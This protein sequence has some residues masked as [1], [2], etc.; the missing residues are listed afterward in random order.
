MTSD[1]RIRM[2]RADQPDNSTPET[3][4]QGHTIVGGRPAGGTSRGGRI[5]RGMEILLKK[6]AVDA[7][8]CARLLLKRS[9][10]SSDLGL[11]LDQAERSMLDAIPEPQ[12][13]AIVAGT[14]VP[15]A[16]KRVLATGSAAAIVALLAQMTFSPVAA[17]AETP[18]D[19]PSVSQPISQPA[20]DSNQQVPGW[21]SLGEGGAR[22]DEPRHIMP[23]GGAR[24]DMPRPPAPPPE[25]SPFIEPEPIAPNEQTIKTGSADF[26][27]RS[28]VKSELAGTTFSQG[29]AR[30]QS[31]IQATITWK[32][33]AQPDWNR[34][35][36]AVTAG[37]GL[38]QALRD[39][40]R[41]LYPEQE[42]EVL[43]QDGALTVLVGD[44]SGSAYSSPGADAIRVPS[45]IPSPFVKPPP[46]P[47]APVPND[48][49]LQITRGIRPDFPDGFDKNKR[50]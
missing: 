32:A 39:L 28:V 14:P 16:Q 30:L 49:D 19:Q 11:D 12:L 5:P 4:D 2:G 46:K 15:E 7:D 47:P 3:P 44:G 43:I 31:D 37:S 24:P 48:D 29:L 38:E 25:P 10:V 45:P 40:A 27:K 41:E 1:N 34:T 13:R 8:F 6:A 22:A 35:I 33:P 18:T 9:A 20:K 21:S 36:E 23:P 17:R 26:L 42:I 50:D